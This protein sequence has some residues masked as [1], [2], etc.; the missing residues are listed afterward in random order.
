MSN[1]IRQIIIFLGAPGSG[2][3]TLSRLCVDKLGWRQLS[4]GD[5]CRHHIEAGTEIGKEI[6]FT[7]KSGTLVRDSVIIEMV[8]QWLKANAETADTVILDGFPRTV[9]QA[10]SFIAMMNDDFKHVAVKIYQ[11]VVPDSEIVERL[12]SRLVCSNKDCQAIYSSREE[13]FLQTN[14]EVCGAKLVRRVDDSFD[15]IN[16]RLSNYHYHIGQLLE[17]YRGLEFHIVS[18]DA[19]RSVDSVFQ[20]LLSNEGLL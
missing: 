5:L 16:S 7:I 1:N 11:L 18:L 20:E 19:N 15:K 17:Y 13:S 12:T 8:A 14:C 4:T 6:D 10:S 2:K 3:G 9:V